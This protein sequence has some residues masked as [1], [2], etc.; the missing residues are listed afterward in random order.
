MVKNK[1]KSVEK[2]AKSTIGLKTNLCFI[3]KKTLILQEK[4]RENWKIGKFPE[5][6]KEIKF[7]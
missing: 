1:R 6:S 5:R 3:V 7:Q 2:S 4:I